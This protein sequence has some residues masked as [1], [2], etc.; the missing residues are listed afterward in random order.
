MM[1]KRGKMV[2]DD[3]PAVLKRFKMSLKVPHDASILAIFGQICLSI[4]FYDSILVSFN[5]SFPQRLTAV[6][7]VK[8]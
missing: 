5:Y 7:L 3:S 6:T 8:L 2:E 1:P 4:L